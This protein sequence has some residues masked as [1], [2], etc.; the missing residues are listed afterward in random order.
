MTYGESFLRGWRNDTPLDTVRKQ[1]G[2]SLVQ[3]IGDYEA[4]K[5]IRTVRPKSKTGKHAET[6]S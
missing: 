4:K 3:M 6:A 2:K 5:K 1:T